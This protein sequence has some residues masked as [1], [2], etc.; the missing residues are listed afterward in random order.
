MRRLPPGLLVPLLLRLT[1]QKPPGEQGCGDYARERVYAPFVTL[2]AVEAGRPVAVRPGALLAREIVQYHY[3]S[4]RT[5][6]DIRLPGPAALVYPAGT[7]VTLDFIDFGDL[8]PC[9][10][11][12]QET[13]GRVWRTRLI[14]C[15]V[16]RDGDGGYE[17]VERLSA[18][19]GA[20]V[21]MIEQLGTMPLP[22]PL[23]LVDDP[24]GDPMFRNHAHRRLIV[25]ALDGDN[26]TLA[27]R[28]TIHELQEVRRPEATGIFEPGPDGSQVY[29]IQPP[30]L[31]IP[32]PRRGDQ[33]RG[34][35]AR[36]IRLAD[37]GTVEVAGLRLRVARV[38]TGWTMTPLDPRF[39]PW[40]VRQCGGRRLYI[41]TPD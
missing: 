19:V 35:D 34:R 10:P 27:V 7:P 13:S 21:P 33:E 8:R 2:A 29:R 12:P 14:L 17:A 5:A 30:D 36:V 20:H 22:A 25:T 18:V 1:A 23:R 26:A 16:D 11:A 32:E 37:G 28:D 38:G 31:S 6:V 15:L 4:W 40:I 41:G 3:P 9:L 24:R 39:A